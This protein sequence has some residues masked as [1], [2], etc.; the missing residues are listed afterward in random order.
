MYRIE[1]NDNVAYITNRQRDTLVARF[2][3]RSF[4]H[5]RIEVYC[6]LCIETR[7]IGCNCDLCRL[8]P[9]YPKRS[10]GQRYVVI[11]MDIMT[12]WA[13]C[14]NWKDHVLLMTDRVEMLGYGVDK[15]SVPFEYWVHVFHDKF[16]NLE[17]V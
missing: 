4:K 15:S 2:N 14:D 1:Y 16:R 3:I 10:F 9:L 7:N 17:K 8:S 5:G 13:G 12:M 11:C 6:P